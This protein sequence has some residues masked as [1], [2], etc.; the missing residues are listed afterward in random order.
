M[1][2]KTYTAIENRRLGKIPDAELES[3]LPSID[4]SCEE[5]RLAFTDMRNDLF[6]VREQFASEQEPDPADEVVD[7]L[8]AD[9]QCVPAT[10]SCSID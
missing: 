4:E 5:Y 7:K 9:I 2:L 3:R 10:V 1:V 6:N 8:K